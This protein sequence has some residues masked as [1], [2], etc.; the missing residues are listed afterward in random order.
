ML[1]SADVL[2]TDNL[3]SA[4]GCTGRQSSQRA[5]CR[6]LA[7]LPTKSTN[8]TIPNHRRLLAESQSD[9]GSI[10]SSLRCFRFSCSSF[11]GIA[12]RLSAKA[13]SSK[14]CILFSC[15]CC[16][17]IL[18]LCLQHDAVARVHLRQLMLIATDACT[19]LGLFRLQCQEHSSK[20][21]TASAGIMRSV[22]SVRPSVSALSF[23]PPDV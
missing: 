7:L 3:F 15:S 8:K 6:A 1:H 13:L 4:R 23:E 12:E 20:L 21:A 16:T 19:E 18:H 22:V 9:S 5:Q 11:L 17:S 2:T 14:G 10:N